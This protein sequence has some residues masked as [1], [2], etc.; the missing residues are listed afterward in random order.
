MQK[1]LT[2]TRSYT[3]RAWS[4]AALLCMVSYP[5]QAVSQSE[6]AFT[7]AGR[8]YGI[9][10]AGTI[11]AALAYV[12]CLLYR[13]GPGDIVTANEILAINIRNTRAIRRSGEK[14]TEGQEIILQ[15][16]VIAKQH[17]RHGADDTVEDQKLESIPGRLS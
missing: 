11:H 5:Q 9:F 7:I 12:R 1:Q 15:C 13:H 2:A 3:I 4:K 6:A 17:R 14:G 10:H 16:A 8:T